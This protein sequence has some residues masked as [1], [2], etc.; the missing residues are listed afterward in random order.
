MY[1]LGKDE[2]RNM[3]YEFETMWLQS[4][5]CEGVILRSWGGCSSNLG[6]DDTSNTIEATSKALLAWHWRKLGNTQ[7]KL[8][9]LLKH[10]SQPPST[11]TIEDEL[12]KTIE[13]LRDRE[14]ALWG[15]RSRAPWLKEGDH[16]TSFFH[17]RAS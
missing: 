7:G 11:E 8:E 16:N 10:T 5:K 14:D 13:E 17:T 1:C 2:R 6:I 15:I 4:N 3:L 12:C 9:E